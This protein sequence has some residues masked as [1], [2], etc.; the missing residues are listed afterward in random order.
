MSFPRQPNECP[1]YYVVK[2]PTSG[3]LSP[4]ERIAMANNDTFRAHNGCYPD[5]PYGSSGYTYSTGKRY[6]RD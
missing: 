3:G 1:D 6:D 2:D 4:Q 5:R